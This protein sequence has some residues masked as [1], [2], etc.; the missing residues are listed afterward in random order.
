MKFSASLIATALL[1]FVIKNA[2]ALPH[3]PGSAHAVKDT[4][5]VGQDEGENDSL[6]RAENGFIA[7][8]VY[9]RGRDVQENGFIARGKQLF[10]DS[11]GLANQ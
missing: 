3:A 9:A 4:T 5:A 8:A 7:R 6:G 10:F 11:P 2:V 1:A